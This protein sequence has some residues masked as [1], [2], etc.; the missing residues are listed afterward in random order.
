MFHPEP[1]IL[2][3][4]DLLFFVERF[5]YTQEEGSNAIILD[6]V[7]VKD[8]FQKCGVCRGILRYLQR[9]GINVSVTLSTI[10]A[11]DFWMKMHKQGL[12]NAI[13]EKSMDRRI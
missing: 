10:E 4:C 9:Q 3:D 7:K 12:I 2:A 13:P 8:K 1:D 11:Y 5:S 6:I